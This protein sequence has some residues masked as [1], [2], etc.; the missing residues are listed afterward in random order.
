MDDIIDALLQGTATN[1]NEALYDPS[2]SIDPARD[3]IFQTPT[4]ND[5]TYPL[6]LYHYL[7]NKATHW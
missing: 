4:N 5:E 7:F 2:I 1:I 6:R 3:S